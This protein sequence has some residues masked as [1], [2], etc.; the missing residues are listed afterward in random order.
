MFVEGW[1]AGVPL[2]PFPDPYYRAVIRYRMEHELDWN[3]LWSI[4]KTTIITGPYH[5]STDS[6]I[7]YPDKLRRYI[8]T[9]TGGDPYERIIYVH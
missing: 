4:Q 7:Y 2:G 8:R 3:Q 1:E 6:P 5:D 9:L